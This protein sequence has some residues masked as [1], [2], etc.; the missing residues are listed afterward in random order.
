MLWIGPTSSVFDW[1][2]YIVMY[3]V[4]CPLFA[5]GEWGSASCNTTLF[6]SLFQT[7]WFVESMWTQS[8]VIHMI[9]TNGVPLVE[10]R[11]SWQ[12]SLATT[13]AISVAV[14]LP[15]TPLDRESAFARGASLALLHFPCHH[16]FAL[17]GSR[18][19]SQEPLSP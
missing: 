16:G 13:L 5:G 18:H 7:G 10:S 8:L 6:I 15:F 14:A 2:T 19:L 3:F 12:L 1:V 9:R 11:A 17:H 4:I